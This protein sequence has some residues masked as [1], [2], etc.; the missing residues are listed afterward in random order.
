MPYLDLTN[1]SDPSEA[2][3]PE[4][5][6]VNVLCTKAEVK[7]NR[8]G[9]GERIAVTFQVTD[10]RFKN[11]FLWTNFNTKNESEIAVI[12]G[13][14]QLKG[15]MMCSGMQSPILDSPQELVGRKVRVHVGVEESAGYDPRNL[16]LGYF[17]VPPPSLNLGDASP[18]EG[19]DKPITT[20]DIP[21]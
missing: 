9:T 13:L 18:L 3:I 5:S 10:G 4:G 21:F 7:G 17:K 20:E 8:S 15:F 14:R 16:I 19:E 2:I 11:V 6:Y 12:M 1:V